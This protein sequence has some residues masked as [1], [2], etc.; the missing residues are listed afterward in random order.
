[1][2]PKKGRFRTTKIHVEPDEDED[3]EN[4]RKLAEEMRRRQDEQQEHEQKDLRK[5]RSQDEEDEEKEEKE[6]FERVSSKKA[7]HFPGVH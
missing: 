6:R 2:I 7:K 3:F 1:M 4:R 5:E